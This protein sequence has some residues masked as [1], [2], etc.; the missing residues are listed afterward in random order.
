MKLV[1]VQRILAGVG[2]WLERLLLVI[3]AGL[4]AVMFVGV[5]LGVVAR[6]ALTVPFP[7]T[8]EIPR[9]CLVWFSP[10]AAA[11]GARRGLHFSFQ[12]GVLFMPERFRMPARLAANLFIIAF[13]F[14]LLNQSFSLIDV[15]ENQIAV[16]SQLDMR[17]PALGI[18]L[19]LIALLTMYALEVADAALAFGTGQSLNPREGLEREISNAVMPTAEA[20]TVE[21]VILNK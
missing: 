14:L 2:L 17:V 13:L 4:L 18:V 12:W 7:W 1:T 19:G 11:I 16:A 15:M 8:E 5:L 10:L 21:S 20:A 6:Q 9:F 3:C